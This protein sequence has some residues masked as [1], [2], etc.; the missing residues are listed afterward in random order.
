MLCFYLSP[1]FMLSTVSHF[2]AL[3]WWYV[4]RKRTLC[5]LMKDNFFHKSANSSHI[6][7]ILSCYQ[8]KK[9]LLFFAIQFFVDTIYVVYQNTLFSMYQ[10]YV[11]LSKVIKYSICFAIHTKTEYKSGTWWW[12]VTESI[13]ERVLCK[14]FYIALWYSIAHLLCIWK[15]KHIFKLQKMRVKQPLSNC[16]DTRR[17]VLSLYFIT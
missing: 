9:A 1:I 17:V 6:I 15:S 14:R 8:R 12:I 7:K 4:R 2:I 16:V 5:S 13:L 3:I 11:F 10:N